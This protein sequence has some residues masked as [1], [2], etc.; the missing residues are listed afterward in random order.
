MPATIN[1]VASTNAATAHTK[2]T[3]KHLS[4]AGPAGAATDSTFQTSESHLKA[5]G[6]SPVTGLDVRNAYSDCRGMLA[7][8][9]EIS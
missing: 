2:R 7:R 8:L 4:G 3:K 6:E 1:T 5:A 9:E